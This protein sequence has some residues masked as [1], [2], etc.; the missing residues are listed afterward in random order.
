MKDDNYRTSLSYLS[1]N[2]D[3]PPDRLNL[4][5]M[6]SSLLGVGILLTWNSFI[7]PVYYWLK[8]YPDFPFMFIVGL[9][10][11]YPYIF[12]V[13][14]TVSLGDKLSDKATC[15]LC[16]SV[17]IVAGLT[18]PL[19]R[20]INFIQDDWGME[21]TITLAIIGVSGVC[22]AC[23][24]SKVLSIVAIL[25]PQYTGAMM[26][27]NGVAGIIALVIYIISYVT[28]DISTLQGASTSSL[29]FFG[30][31]SIISGLCVVGILLFDKLEFVKYYQKINSSDSVYKPL[32][33]GVESRSNDDGT[34]R[35][36]VLRIIWKQALNVFITF[37][38][39]LSL[40]PGQITLISPQ[41]LSIVPVSL[42][43]S[44]LI[45]IFQVFDF[46]G[47]TLPA[48][49]VLVNKDNLW[50]PTLIRLIF[51]PLIIILAYPS[52]SHPLIHNDWIAFV[53]IAIFALTNGYLGTFAMIF[54]PA[55][56]ELSEYQ[57]PIAGTIMA[58]FL[59]LGILLG[60]H[61]G[62]LLKG[63]LYKNFI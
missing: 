46:I 23:L 58:F 10:F 6:I 60:Q 40:F 28:V 45:G 51:Y 56:S 48:F 7:T 31:G 47:R 5:W 37:F 8:L 24:M 39:T 63:I 20:Y 16:Y 12:A 4:A 38:I 27:G 9:V 19:L 53:I 17:N 29:I 52:S 54:G 21:L 41:P 25:P 22:S 1:N 62:F 59:S 33:D 55:D 44:I 49:V 42:M 14:M 15:V 26:S 13:G 30:V 35:F 3:P 18:V 61:C 43:G 32:L 11:N 36:Q 34:S 2:Q 50:I 57:R